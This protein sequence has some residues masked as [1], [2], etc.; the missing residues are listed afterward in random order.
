MKKKQLLYLTLFFFAATY[1]FCEEANWIELNQK[2]IQLFKTGQAK[3]ACSLGTPYVKRLQEDFQKNQKISADAV[4]FLVNQGILCKQAGQYEEALE[5]LK[6]SLEC[7]RK[8]AS[9]NDPL[10]VSIYK[11]LGEI[12]Q[13]RKNYEDGEKYFLKS[14]EIKETNMGKNNNELVPL[15]LTLGGFYQ[16][17]EKEDK[18][19]EVYEKALHISKEKNGDENNVTADVYFS[20][21]KYYYTLKNYKKAEEAFLRSFSIYDKNKDNKKIVFSYD[22]LGLLNQQKGNLVDAESYFRL[23]AKQKALTLGKTSLEY[24]KSLNNLGSLYVMQE[25]KEAEAILKEAFSI[26]EKKFG[27]EHPS[28]TPTINN[29]IA[30]YTKFPNDA[31]LQKYTELLKKINRA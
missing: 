11:S 19:L 3:K 10:F 31:E 24:A 29:L 30:Y 25:K 16:A 8:I 23:S 28:L 1:L 5:T 13:T 17:F 21:G 15:F 18:A 2:M 27:P 12:A 26:C 22:Y 7:K 20:I 14:I 9:P 6:L 4:V